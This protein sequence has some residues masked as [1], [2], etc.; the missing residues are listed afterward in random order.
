MV[1]EIIAIFFFKFPLLST[2]QCEL[3]VLGCRVARVKNRT[4]RNKYNGTMPPVPPPPPASRAPVTPTSC[5]RKT[6]EFRP[7]TSPSFAFEQMQNFLQTA[8]DTDGILEFLFHFVGILVF[9]NPFQAILEGF[10]FR[11]QSIFKKG[12]IDMYIYIYIYLE[13]KWGSIFIFW[14]IFD[15]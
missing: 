1:S 6:M 12:L 2:K 3:F 5:C 13:P 7:W 14:K 9:R 15:P 11:I 10:F 8:P 4:Y